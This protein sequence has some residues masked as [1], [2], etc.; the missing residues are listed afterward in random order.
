ML[1]SAGDRSI[2][3][4]MAIRR[5]CLTHAAFVAIG[6]FFGIVA[7]ALLASVEI[8]TTNVDCGIAPVAAVHHDTPGCEREGRN[9]TFGAIAAGALSALLL[10]G[11]RMA[12]RRWTRVAPGSAVDGGPPAL[13]EAAITELRRYRRRAWIWTAVG[14]VL[15]AAFLVAVTNLYDDA[16][17]LEQ[18]GT[19]VPG[20][21]ENVR[22]HGERGSVSVAFEYDGVARRETINL[23]AESHDYELGHPVTVII[24]PDDPQHVTLPGETN[25]SEWG[26][27][28]FAI[29][30]VA[31]VGMI[32]IGIGS[33]VR[34]NHQRV[35]LSTFP[36]RSLPVRYAEIPGPRGSVRSILLVLPPDLVQG[37]V[38][39]L[40]GTTRWRLPRA[41]MAA[42]PVCDI[43]GPLPGY[44]VLRTPG[45]PALYSA[46]PPYWSRAERKWRRVLDS[47][48]GDGDLTF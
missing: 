5:G 40:A 37:V 21:V 38:L 32:L 6:I 19:R 18:T 10:A 34:S 8:E 15:L 47:A 25:Q 46:R 33:I 9:Q 30:L 7:I 20:T 17:E 16:D 14:V 4:W 28:V 43:A 45:N 36:W 24:D 22:G 44:V 48:N 27:F 11:P 12:R 2:I 1:C 3:Q 29:L 13:D 31:G 23:D 35:V 39:T 26:V 41:A 42:S